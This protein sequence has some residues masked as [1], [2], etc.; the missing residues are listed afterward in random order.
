MS[1]KNLFLLNH[2][3]NV[4]IAVEHGIDSAIMLGNIF[5]WIQHNEANE[6]NFFD[7]RYWTYNSQ[8]AFSDLFPYWNRAKIQ[9]IL[10]Y[11]EEQGLLMKGNYNKSAYDRTT[12][13]ALTDKGLSLF[14]VQNDKMHCSDLNNG[15]FENEQSNVQNRTIESSEMSNQMFRNEQPIPDINTDKNSDEKLQS[16]TQSKGGLIEW[17]KYPRDF[18]EKH[19]ETAFKANDEFYLKLVELIGEVCNSDVESYAINKAQV[20]A[21]V[22][23][24]RLLKLN[25]FHLE[26]VIEEYSKLTAKVINVRAY[27]IAMLYNSPTTIDA[28]YINKVRVDNAQL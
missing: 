25:Q 27:L 24:S 22:V 15:E 9:R 12:W 4:G 2:S 18:F 16:I 28:S 14:G 1:S 5:F 13:F 20:P 21:E 8:K 17:A 23:K 3:F 11:L 7:G 6:K 26:Y 10:S 19:F